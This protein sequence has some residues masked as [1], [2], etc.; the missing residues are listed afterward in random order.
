MTP[1]LARTAS[2]GALAFA[3]S[4][5]TAALA[6]TADKDGGYHEAEGTE[7]VVTGAVQVSRKDVLSGVAIVTG[8]ELAEDV[9]PSLGETLAGPPGV[10]ATL[11]ALTVAGGGLL[12]SELVTAV[13][14]A[15]ELSRSD[16]RSR[17]ASDAADAVTACPFG[18]TGKAATAGEA[19]STGRGA[20]SAGSPAS[21]T[22]TGLGASRTNP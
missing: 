16:I 5:P 3:L 7:I 22:F 13:A 6:Q 14:P 18:A 17:S 15:S 4:L 8:T 2:L 12:R 11:A 10:S 21:G 20:T 9:R 19:A 1:I